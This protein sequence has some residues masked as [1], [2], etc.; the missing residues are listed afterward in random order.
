[1]VMGLIVWMVEN[2][3]VMGY[4]LIIRDQWLKVLG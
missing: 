3:D 2:F 1:M 4:E